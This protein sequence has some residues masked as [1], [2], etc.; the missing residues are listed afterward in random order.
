MHACNGYWLKVEG[1]DVGQSMNSTPASRYLHYC[2]QQIMQ[3]VPTKIVKTSSTTFAAACAFVENLPIMEEPLPVM[4]LLDSG[5]RL[6]LQWKMYS[7]TFLV[8]FQHGQ[9]ISGEYKLVDG[10]VIGS[11][12]DPLKIAILADTAVGEMK[13]MFIT[14]RTRC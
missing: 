13:Q 12:T 4:S 1:L 9:I 3:N 11:E 8:H 14:A 2:F 10:Y 6:V 7:Y 5:T